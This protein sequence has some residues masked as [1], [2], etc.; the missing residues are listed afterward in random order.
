V[1]KC[2]A[3]WASPFGRSGIQTAADAMKHDGVNPET[4][5]MFSEG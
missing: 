2:S 3:R 4:L 5:L 1:K